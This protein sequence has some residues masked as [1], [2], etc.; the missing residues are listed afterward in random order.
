MI[1]ICTWFVD[2]NWF[3]FLEWLSVF[4]SDT[5]FHVEA[6]FYEVL[7]LEIDTAGFQLL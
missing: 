5:A 4:H 3:E 7:K 2:Y 6:L 1:E